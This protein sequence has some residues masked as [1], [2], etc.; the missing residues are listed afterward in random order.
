[1][2]ELKT[3]IN[4]NIA[5]ISEKFSVITRLTSATDK[6]KELQNIVKLLDELDD[7]Y[8]MFEKQMIKTKN[9]KQIYG[10]DAQ[11]LDDKISEFKQKL[12]DVQ[13][14]VNNPS[15][16]GKDKS[17]P[18]GTGGNSKEQSMALAAKFA[19]GDNEIARGREKIENIKKG[20]KV[21]NQEID[22][23]E[24]EIEL[25]REKLQ[26]VRENLDET[27]SVI[28][29]T[30]MILDNIS[31]M[32]FHDTLLKILI[33]FITLAIL[34]IIGAACFVKAK[35]SGLLSSG[36]DVADLEGEPNY[37]DIDENF[38]MNLAKGTLDYAAAI[39]NTDIKLSV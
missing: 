9:G 12:V 24:E 21:I 26:K 35:K 2:D 18:G 7:D 19:E 28:G 34:G 11:E 17:I 3:T 37:D 22:G 1:M 14:E 27:R 16:A 38:F 6:E 32:L 25:Q 8:S 23:I 15:G 30:K 5:Q 31:S 13:N 36:D 39:S 29:Q 20:L 10:D 33:V 4:K